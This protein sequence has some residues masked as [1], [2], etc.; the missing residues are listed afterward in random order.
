MTIGKKKS[1]EAIKLLYSEI[2]HLKLTSEDGEEYRLWKSKTNN[3]IR[4]IFGESSSEYTS[5]Y[6]TLFPSYV[7]LPSGMSVDYHQVFL[8]R[9]DSLYSELKGMEEAVNLWEDEN[10]IQK[11]DEI[12][13]LID[14]LSRFHKFAR[15]LKCRYNQRKTIEIEDEYD[16]QDLL[17]AILKLHFEDVRP[18]EYQPS[19][20]GSSTRVDFLL[21]NENIIIEVKKTRSNLKDKEVGEQLISDKAHYRTNSDYKTL[22]CFIYDPDGLLNNPVGLKNDLSETNSNM[23][24]IVIICPNN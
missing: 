2:P 20:A 9:L 22:V 23:N 11:K 15:Q 17:H 18:E 8:R 13:I 19:Y 24:T 4:Q 7:G 16:V 21:K 5:I 3:I 10:S 6:T 1:L 12:Q 14:I